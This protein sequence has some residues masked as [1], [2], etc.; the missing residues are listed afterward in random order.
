V[1]W[2]GTIAESGE[3]EQVVDE[4]AE[5]VEFGD[6]VRWERATFANVLGD[7]ELHPQRREWAA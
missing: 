7:I 2:T 1:T 6:Q 5:S 3:D 4:G